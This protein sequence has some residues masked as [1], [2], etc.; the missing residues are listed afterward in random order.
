M[1]ALVRYV[2]R[3]DRCGIR[4]ESQRAKLIEARALARAEGWTRPVYRPDLNQ[5]RIDACPECSNTSGRGP[6]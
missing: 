5:K 4:F 6:R 1:T 2:I 3:C